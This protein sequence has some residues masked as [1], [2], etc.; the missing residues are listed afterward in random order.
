MKENDLWNRLLLP[1]FGMATLWLCPRISFYRS[2]FHSA[3]CDYFEV[4]YC[5]LIGSSIAAVFLSSYLGRKKTG[6]LIASSVASVVASLFVPAGAALSA[7]SETLGQLFLVCLGSILSGLG[8]GVALMAWG[9][10][11]MKMGRAGAMLSLVVA[12]IVHMTLS[13]VVSCLPEDTCGVAYMALL[14]LSALCWILCR[15]SER[16]RNSPL[17]VSAFGGSDSLLGKLGR[18]SL[19]T[20]CASK[21]STNRTVVMLGIFICVGALLWGFLAPSDTGAVTVAQHLV[22]FFV[23]GTTFALL[24]AGMCRTH[25]SKAFGAIRAATAILFFIGL[26]ACLL[27]GTDQSIIGTSTIMAAKFCLEG[28]AWIVV[29]D[30]AIRSGSAALKVF[31]RGLCL[32]ILLPSLLGN[33]VFPFAVRQMGLAESIGHS[34]VFLVAAFA[35]IVS[36]ILL[37]NGSDAASPTLRNGLDPSFGNRESAC[38]GIATAYGLTPRETDVLKLL[39]LGHSQQRIADTLC[40]APTTIQS[41]VKSI[42]RKTGLHNKQQVIDLANG[43]SSSQS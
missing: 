25:P 35:L 34:T 26:F 10:A 31:G 27:V 7:I 32:L 36:T 42:Y 21:D 1:V 22:T 14:L 13:L 20:I 4:Y 38:D 6:V 11:L 28:Y 23:S 41:H 9:A 29:V 17:I 30:I 37:L 15:Q 2:L 43:G 8:L 40:V 16:G 24:L 33:I 19:E 18:K 5:L 12:F 3:A 39:S